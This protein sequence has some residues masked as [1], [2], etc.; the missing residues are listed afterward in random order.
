MRKLTAF[1]TTA[2]L[3]AVHEIASAGVADAGWSW[4]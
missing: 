2:A 1:L 4:R 3:I